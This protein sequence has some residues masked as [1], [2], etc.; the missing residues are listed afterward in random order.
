M[1]RTFSLTGFTLCFWIASSLAAENRGASA[2]DIRYALQ[3][4]SEEPGY[5]AAREFPGVRYQ[6]VVKRR[7]AKDA[8]AFHYLFALST[9]TDGAASEL[10]SEILAVVLKHVGDGSSMR[11]FNMHQRHLAKRQSDI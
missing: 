4:A 1:L 5:V 7:L 9:K 2:K 6:D 11:N 10:Q 8:G 3:W